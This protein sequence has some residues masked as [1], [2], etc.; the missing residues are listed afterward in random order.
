MPQTDCL[1]RWY[2]YDW[3]WSTLEWVC[4]DKTQKVPNEWLDSEKRPRMEYGAYGN[5][6]AEKEILENIFKMN[7][8]L[9]WP[10]MEMGSY[11][12]HRR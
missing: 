2:A 6:H 12:D 7:H 4:Q 3:Q 10:V 9:V 1:S 5:D 8:W 11:A